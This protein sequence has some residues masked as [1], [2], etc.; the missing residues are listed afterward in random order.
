MCFDQ[1]MKL[2]MNKNDGSREE[3]RKV[4]I[5]NLFSPI[6]VSSSSSSHLYFHKLRRLL[7]TTTN[8]TAHYSLILVGPIHEWAPSGPLLSLCL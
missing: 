8:D 7:F 4:I 6:F 1:K 5:T 2:K 3:D